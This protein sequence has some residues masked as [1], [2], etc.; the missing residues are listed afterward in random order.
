LGKRRRERLT[1]V[2]FKRQD[3][4]G[5]AIQ[6]NLTEYAFR[7]LFPAEMRLL[8]FE[9]QVK[10]FR[11]MLPR[12][13]REEQYDVCIFDVTPTVLF[14]PYIHA[15]KYIFRLN[16]Q[17]CRFGQRLHERIIAILELFV[18]N[19][20]CADIWAVS[21][22]LTEYALALDHGCA[23]KIFPNGINA[24]QFPAPGLCGGKV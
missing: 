23:P 12:R 6:P 4:E 24:E 16:D 19:R 11:H 15:G 1:R 10:T 14:L 18:R 21:Q 17:P 2:W 3:R 20:W 22:P 5:F 8:R 7:A 9:W 13:F